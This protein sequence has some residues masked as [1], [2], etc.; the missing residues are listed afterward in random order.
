VQILNEAVLMKQED[1]EPH[2]KK[3]LSALRDELIS[4]SE[5]NVS[6]P[7]S[8]FVKPKRAVMPPLNFQFIPVNCANP[9]PQKGDSSFQTKFRYPKRPSIEILSNIVGQYAAFADAKCKPVIK[10]AVVGGDSALHN[11]ISSFINLKK[12]TPRSLDGL[13]VQI[14]LI[15]VESNMFGLFLS[16]YDGWYGRHVYSLCKGLLR[17]VPTIVPP[18]PTN[19]IERPTQMDTP[20]PKSW[21]NSEFDKS[22]E[23]ISKMNSS[24]NSVSSKQMSLRL[25]S[26]SGSPGIFQDLKQLYADEEK[27]PS[28]SWILRSEVEN[29]FREAKWKLEVN[30][31]H[32]ECWG[33]D[34]FYYTIPFFQRA[35]LGWK[36][37]SRY[38]QKPLPD[39]QPGS[40]SGKV[41]K[42]APPTFV[43]KC[44]QMNVLGVSR[45]GPT[46]EAK[47]YHSIV[48]ANIPVQGDRG[49]PP[50]PSKPWLERTL[51]EVDKKKKVVQDA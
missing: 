12:S 18:S 50:N 11:V 20:K 45:P 30:A 34:S 1:A 31:Y 47:S 29:L 24:L 21:T 7:A 26:E 32:C 3:A 33:E 14:F 13:E 23:Q 27:P 38:V 36:P 44:T 49:V 2:R 39:P 46:M 51:I 22:L 42:W 5:A 25:K 37:Y 40:S 16:R 41:L 28:P 4:Q 10:I 35:E 9:I 15:P 17:A 19:S 8:G 43:L 6:K 48:I